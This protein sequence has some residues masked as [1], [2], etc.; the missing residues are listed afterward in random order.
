[1]LATV[2][3]RGCVGED[4]GLVA[5]EATAVGRRVGGLFEGCFIF[6]FIFNIGLQMR[7]DD[8]IMIFFSFFS[9][10]DNAGRSYGSSVE[11]L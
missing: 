6:I 7:R 3:W 5:V 1:M 8:G 2:G 11:N 4:G 10:Y 9:S